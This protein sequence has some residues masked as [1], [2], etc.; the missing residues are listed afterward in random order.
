MT[1]ND[2]EKERK[3]KD[4]SG[5]NV[6]TRIHA[7]YP[8]MAPTFEDELYWIVPSVSTPFEVKVID[9]MFVQASLPQNELIIQKSRTG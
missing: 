3:E 4:K 6:S 1:A 5:W 7:L 9:N 2:M 8:G